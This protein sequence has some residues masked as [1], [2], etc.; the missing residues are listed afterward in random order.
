MKNTKLFFASLMLLPLMNACSGDSNALK[1]YDGIK[2]EAPTDKKPTIQ[3]VANQQADAYFS[4]EVNGSDSVNFVNVTQGQSMEAIMKITPNH[5]GIKAYDVQLV[6][7]PV[8]DGPTLQNNQNGTYTLKWTPALGTV[9][10]GDGDKKFKAQ[11]QVSVKDATSEELLKIVKNYAVLIEVQEN[12]S[13]PSIESRSKLDEIEEGIPAKLE[14]VVDDPG[15]AVDT[16]GSPE[17]VIT[18]FPYTNKEAFRADGQP[19]VFQDSVDK[20]SGTK[21]KFTMTIYAESLPLGRDRLG[22]EV[23]SSETVP[24]CFYMRALGV[25]ERLSGKKE[26]CF[27]GKYA[28]Q[29]PT[30]T[31]ADGAPSDVK[32]GT[33][34][35]FT[36]KLSTPNPKSQLSVKNAAKQ[37]AN[38]SGTK[39]IECSNDSANQSNAQ[40]CTVTWKPACVKAAVKTSLKIT[41]DATLNSKVKSSV[42]TKDLTVLPNPEAC[43]GG[44]R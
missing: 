23:P 43:T 20:L 1:D 41:A 31:L 3:S 12:S 37:I 39:T 34:N 2:G 22:H 8:A 14:V 19:Y 44:R 32:A 26:V 16:V 27:T 6:D 13:Q 33:Q 18:S 9:P 21:W 30:L 36:I 29:P 25:T 10:K 35:I 17:M 5:P 24:V 7:F 4:F 15:T 42:L 40:T 28:A 38:L 11:I